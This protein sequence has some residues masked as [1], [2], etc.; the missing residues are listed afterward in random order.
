MLIRDVKPIMYQNFINYISE[1]G[2]SRR[3]VELI[4]STMHNALQ[5]AVIIGKLE[6]IHV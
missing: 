2:Y 5:K 3:T 1:K 4:H 6:K